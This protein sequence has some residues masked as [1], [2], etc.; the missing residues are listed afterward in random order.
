MAIKELKIVD[1]SDGAKVLH[2]G[3]ER[4]LQELAITALFALRG[5]TRAKNTKDGIELVQ[6]PLGIKQAQNIAAVPIFHQATGQVRHLDFSDQNPGA[7][8]RMADL[9]N[10]DW[11]FATAAEEAKAS[12]QEAVDRERIEADRQK[13]IEAPADRIGA[14]IA[15]VLA[16]NQ[17]NKRK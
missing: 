13:A 5:K 9:M 14:K 4:E 2:L 3:T 6:C 12:A 10:G 11:R 8:A 1:P 16:A 17:E 7:R 15:A